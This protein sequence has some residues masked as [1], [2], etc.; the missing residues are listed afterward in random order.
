MLSRKGPNETSTGIAVNS[1]LCWYNCQNRG[2][3]ICITV[4]WNLLWNRTFCLLF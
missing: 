1:A 4:K 2:G 3:A